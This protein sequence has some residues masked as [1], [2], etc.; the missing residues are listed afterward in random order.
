MTNNIPLNGEILYN[1]DKKA[2]KIGDGES[3]IKDL[4]VSNSIITRGIFED[5]KEDILQAHE[6]FYDE[7]TNYLYFGNGTS[8][9]GDLQPII[10]T[11]DI[12]NMRI[13]TDEEFLT[14]LS[15]VFGPEE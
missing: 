4:S 15:A 12:V 10:G 13:A 6:I 7:N 5:H 11:F 2:L 3:N 9:L 14:M 1:H 8:K